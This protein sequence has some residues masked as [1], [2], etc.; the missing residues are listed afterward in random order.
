MK[1]YQVILSLLCFTYI[2]S[3]IETCEEIRS[4]SAETC[5]KGLSQYDI[6]KG[7]SKCCFTKEKRHKNS[8]ESIACTPFSQNQLEN[9][10]YMIHLGKIFG[11]VYELSVDCSSVFFKLSFLSLILILL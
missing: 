8:E 6:I 1:T 11:E 4:P 3:A 10:E 2:Y 9:L 5:S 7:Y